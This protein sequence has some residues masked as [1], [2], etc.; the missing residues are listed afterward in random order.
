[1]RAAVAEPLGQLLVVKDVAPPA[2]GPADVLLKVE[3][4][5]V[6]YTD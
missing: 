2:I 5:G 1:M 6:C 4:C 3:A